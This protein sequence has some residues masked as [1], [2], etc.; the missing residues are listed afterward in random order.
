[1]DVFAIS[2]SALA[3]GLSLIQFFNDFS[4]QKKEATL[5]AYGKL[6]DEVFPILRQYH[7]PM[8][9]AEYNTE[10]WDIFTECLAKLEQFSVGVNTG[11]YSV[12]ILNRVGGGYFIR[13]YE[14]LEPTIKEKRKENRVPGNHYNE[15][16]ETVNRLKNIRKHHPN[17]KNADG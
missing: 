7:F 13:Q 8:P 15:F 16:E 3:L 11:I 12:Q 17:R 4:R 2:I 9:A 14:K 6:Q 5:L 1:M 10:E